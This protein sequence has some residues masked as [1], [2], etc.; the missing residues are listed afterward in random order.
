LET[1]VPVRS[2]LARCY[3]VCSVAETL[4]V[5]I[6]NGDSLDDINAALIEY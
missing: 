2:R 6:V 3:A 5:K 4:F 1:V